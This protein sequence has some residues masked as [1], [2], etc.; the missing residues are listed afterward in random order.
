MTT[1]NTTQELRTYGS[2]QIL[3]VSSSAVIQRQSYQYYIADDYE[4]Q[5]QT[6]LGCF[7][8]TWYVFLYYHS[9]SV[10]SLTLKLNANVLLRDHRPGLPR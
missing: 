8:I 4:I 1:T 2:C 6:V 9:G 5:G 7:A 3:T 10:S